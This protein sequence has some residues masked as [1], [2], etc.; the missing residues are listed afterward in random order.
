MLKHREQLTRLVCQKKK[1]KKWF[2]L[3]FILSYITLMHVLKQKSFYKLKILLTFTLNFSVK[4]LLNLQM[5][6][7][8]R[9]VDFGVY[10]AQM[11][12]FI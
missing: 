9:L 6:C 2:C 8:L 5:V 11:K 7:W 12:T 10:N 1:K 4:T 3:V